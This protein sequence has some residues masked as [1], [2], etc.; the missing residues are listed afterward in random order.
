MHL[1]TVLDRLFLPMASG[2]RLR[3]RLTP[4]VRA[5]RRPAAPVGLAC[6]Q[7]SSF[8]NHD[9]DR[10]VPEHRVA[11]QFG[12]PGVPV[13]Q[14]DDG[15]PDRG[16][17]GNVGAM[18][19]HYQLRRDERQGLCPSNEQLRRPDD[20]PD[21]VRGPGRLHRQLQD[22]DQRVRTSGGQRHL[23]QYSGIRDAHR[24]L[25]LHSEPPEPRSTEQHQ[26]EHATA[27]RARLRKRCGNREQSC[28]VQHQP[29]E[30]GTG[31][32]TGTVSV[33]QALSAQP[34][35]S[36]THARGKKPMHAAISS[37]KNA[38]HPLGGLLRPR[39]VGHSRGVKIH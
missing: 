1:P 14:L 19:W 37:H 31:T 23:E 24:H 35:H 30:R 6:G 34:Q 12:H 20:G 29:N 26:P 10:D 39:L 9:P 33:V 4:A 8:G 22:A 27:Q 2:R 28:I 7:P 36:S 21:V 11:S 16:G 38:H 32:P 13:L 5:S 3:R 18:Q 15:N 17:P 25:P